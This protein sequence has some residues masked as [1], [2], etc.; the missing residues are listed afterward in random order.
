LAI[1]AAL[2][3][4]DDDRATM[5]LVRHAVLSPF[6][7]VRL[8]ATG[9]LTKRPLHDFVPTLMGQL[10]PPLESSYSVVPRADGSVYYTHELFEQGPEQ[11]QSKTFLGSFRQ[12]GD[13][14]NYAVDI[15]VRPR[16]GQREVAIRML[17]PEE[18]REV[19]REKQ[20]RAMVRSKSYLTQA[21][22]LEQ[23]LAQLNQTREEQNGRIVAVLA[24]ITDQYLGDDP[25]SWWQWWRNYN[26]LE[27]NEIPTYERT[28]TDWQYNPL[29]LYDTLSFY[30]SCFPQGTPVWTRTGQKAIESV[31][32]GDW[33]LAQDPDT[34]QLAFKPVLATTFGEPN[35]LIEVTTEGQTLRATLGHPFWVNGKGWQM[36]KQLE[37]GDILH[38][39]RGPLHIDR[40]AKTSPEEA[41]NLV[42]HDFGTYFVGAAGILV[43]DI[44][45]RQPTRALVPGLAAR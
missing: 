38:T 16:T 24:Q 12:D 33:V 29:R 5:S 17:S 8:A 13:R 43:H 27:S 14:R 6:A 19:A 1:V 7:D 45:I 41:Y 26:E 4:M 15:T 44:T 22:N 31:R 10:K 11:N 34:G 2:G 32:K 25:K 42:V 37:A 23:S 9:Q 20:R 39:V 30:H 3:R 18:M 36:A 35:P 40:V 21:F 28:Y